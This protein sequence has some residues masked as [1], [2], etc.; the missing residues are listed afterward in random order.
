[1]HSA[2]ISVIDDLISELRVQP[3]DPVISASET[4]RTH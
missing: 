2:N 3:S 1:M 4:R